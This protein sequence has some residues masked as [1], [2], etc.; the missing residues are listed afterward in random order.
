VFNVVIN[1]TN[2]SQTAPI[3]AV[4]EAGAANPLVLNPSRI[5]SAVTSR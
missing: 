4:T 3:A 1:V 2:V 5:F